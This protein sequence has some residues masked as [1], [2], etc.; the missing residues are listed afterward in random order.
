MNRV[1]WVVKDLRHAVEGWKSLGLADVHE[2]GDLRIKASYRG[3][4]QTSR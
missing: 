2:D 3:K 4:A 1:T